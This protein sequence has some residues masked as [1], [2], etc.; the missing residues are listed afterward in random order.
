[1]KLIHIS[2]VIPHFS[3]E[4]IVGLCYILT[5]TNLYTMLITQ[6]YLSPGTLYILFGVTAHSEPE[7]PHS[8]GF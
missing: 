6:I 2:T 5:H 8:R 3:K 7:P 1:M 4:F